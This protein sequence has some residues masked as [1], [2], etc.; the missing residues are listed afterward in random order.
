MEADM[1]KR[2]P[3]V[4]IVGFGEVGRSVQKLFP[5]AVCYD[6]PLAIGAREQVNACTYAFVAV[7]TPSLPGGACDTS[8]VEE[9]A[10]WLEADV[11]I[12]LSTVAPGTTE[13]LVEATGKRIVFQ[14]MYGP[15]E[16][17]GHPYGDLMAVR[18]LILGGARAVTSRVADLYKTVYN[19]ETAIWQTDARTAE[20]A[21][22]MENAFLALKVTFCNEFYDIAEGFGVDY[23]ELRELWLQDPRMGRSHTFVFPD[24][25][26]YGGKCLPKDVD[27]IIQASQARGYVPRLLQ[28]MAETNAGFR[29]GGP[30]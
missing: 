8:I 20:L 16:T 24:D 1:A 3:A 27:A 23:N 25:R 4:G 28:A 22:Y 30:A 14:P 2:G 5:A 11:I 21:K 6:E 29:S 10:G 19:A 18:W 12:L 26:G 15:G 17:P 9:V 7:P 13:R